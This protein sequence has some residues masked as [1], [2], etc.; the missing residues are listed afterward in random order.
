MPAE[1]VKTY[2][3]EYFHGKRIDPSVLEHG[4]SISS[5]AKH[6]ELSEEQRMNSLLL[7]KMRSL[8]S[9][10]SLLVSGW[11]G[12]NIILRKNVVVIESEITYFDTLDYSATYIKTAYEVRCRGREI[13]Q[14]F[15]LASVL[16]VFDHA[17]YAKLL[18]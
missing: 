16:C 18:K 15:L 11:T 12:F 14:R 9:S 7:I 6:N 5:D 8:K 13:K 10:P 4:K 2:I 3:T 1:V 17:F